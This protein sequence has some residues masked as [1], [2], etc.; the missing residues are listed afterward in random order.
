MSKCHN[1]LGGYAC[2]WCIDICSSSILCKV[3]VTIYQYLE[4]GLQ[5]FVEYQV[6]AITVGIVGDLSRALEDKILPFCNGILTQLLK[7]LS[8]KQERAQTH[9]RGLFLYRSG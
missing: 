4:M 8:S 9:C 7:D 1:A 6:C 3:H 5:N 2:Y